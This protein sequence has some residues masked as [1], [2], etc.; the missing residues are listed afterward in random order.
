MFCYD[1]Y[2]KNYYCKP[3]PLLHCMIQVF[4][5]HKLLFICCPLC[6]HVQYMNMFVA[7]YIYVNKL[8]C[9]LKHKTMQCLTKKYFDISETQ[10]FKD[11]L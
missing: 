4:L 9:I 11:L 5:D 3:L 7:I 10:H 6:H 1:L 8:H 2:I